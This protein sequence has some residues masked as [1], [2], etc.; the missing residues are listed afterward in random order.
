MVKRLTLLKHSIIYAEVDLSLN[1]AYNEPWGQ[2]QTV[3]HILGA[4]EQGEVE[5]IEEVYR[6]DID[7][8][9]DNM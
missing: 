1:L 2:T 9:K 7:L 4:L 8:W 6:A 5:E 3:R